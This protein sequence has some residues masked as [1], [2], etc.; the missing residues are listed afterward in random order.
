VSNININVKDS[1]KIVEVW[2]TIAEKSSMVQKR[3]LNKL[4]QEYKLQKYIIVVYQS[5]SRNLA[6]TII[7]L[8]LHNR[9]A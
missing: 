9:N 6:D 1:E 3:L 2:L 8:L 4:C 7:S 5:G